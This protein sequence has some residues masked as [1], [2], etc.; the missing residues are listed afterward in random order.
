[1][2]SRATSLEGLASSA[3]AGSR[4][5]FG[6]LVARLHGPLFDFLRMRTG[7]DADA[8]EICQ[9]AFLRAWQEI[10]RY[11]PARSFKTWLFT[12]GKRLAV[13]RYRARSRER[14]QGEEQATEGVSE[15]Q[16]PVE[17]LGAVDE[18]RHI[19]QVAQRALEP[20]PR[21]ALW[22]RY[23]EDLSV[24]EIASVLGRPAV[25]VRVILFRARERLAV[26]LGPRPGRGE[27]R[28][29]GLGARPVLVREE[30]G[31]PL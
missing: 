30:G 7:N 26:A 29:P 18:Q 5:A 15:Q 24:G 21:A 8:E 14:T 28:H 23:A 20:E 22:L 6:E 3:Q 4:A 2:S 1:M 13:S 12:V 25:T 11:D 27:A 17:I 9:E 10:A 31:G 19:W 16:D